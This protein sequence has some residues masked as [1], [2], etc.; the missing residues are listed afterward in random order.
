MIV[1]KNPF[2]VF[3]VCEL[4][5][6]IAQFVSP[7]EWHQL[8]RVDRI[9][10]LAINRLI[11]SRERNSPGFASFFWSLK[12]MTIP[13]FFRSVKKVMK[14]ASGRQPLEISC[15]FFDGKGLKE[16]GSLKIDLKKI[17]ILPKKTLKVIQVNIVFFEPSEIG[18]WVGIYFHKIGSTCWLKS[19]AYAHMF[20]VTGDLLD[21]FCRE[22]SCLY[23]Q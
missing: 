22:V 1:K 10:K 15:H 4:C 7:K 5:Y 3:S 20:H 14:N 23:L 19:D 2:F 6:E 17:S 11:E 12:M 13:D 8:Q 9:W 21:S 16:I 18:L